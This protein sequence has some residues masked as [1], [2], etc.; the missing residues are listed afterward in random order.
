M[1][2][3]A[4]DALAAALARWRLGEALGESGRWDEAATPL[5]A[6]L[7][8]LEAAPGPS[9]HPDIAHVCNGAA[10][11]HALLCVCTRAGEVSI[12]HHEGSE[13]H[14]SVGGHSLLG[15]LLLV[16]TAACHLSH[17]DSVWSHAISTR[18]M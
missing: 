18:R 9:S 1:A 3:A 17:G 8:A 6:A 12:R 10:R 16:V 5:A 13:L 11:Q 2:E 4:G 14:A 15:A 7:A